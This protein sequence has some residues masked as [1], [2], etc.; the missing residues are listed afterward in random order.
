[1]I[2]RAGAEPPLC[3]P[4]RP[5]I[6]GPIHSFPAGTVDTHF[7]VFETGAPLAPQRN[8]TPHMI[9]LDDWLAFAAAFGI[10]RGVLIQPSVYGSDNTV[11][12]KALAMDPERLRG[13]AVVDANASASEL[14]R[15]HAAGVRGIRINT[16]NPGGLGLAD[17]D[18]IAARLAPLGWHI[19][20]LVGSRSLDILRSSASSSPV[21]LV[22]DHFGLL[23]VDDP[24]NL[25]AAVA[26]LRRALDTGNCYVKL[27]A[28]YRLTSGRR[29]H[30]FA[31]IVRT[32]VRGHADRVL[33][34]S[35]WPHTELFADMPGDD[36][37]VQEALT[38][39]ADHDVRRRVLIT[40]PT[41]LY[42]DH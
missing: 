35:D 11:L 27:S 36:D 16:R 26:S 4:P 25:P 9:T 31:E 8:Y 1:M 13:V 7:H 24:A 15:L 20:L 2:D 33:W 32:L 40:N 29:P 30:E 41:R 12:L 37:L 6:P 42:W 10:E 39:L 5:T 34:G 21:P 23:P 28:P 17:F 22:V 19:Q 3:L 14:R 18:R 38:W